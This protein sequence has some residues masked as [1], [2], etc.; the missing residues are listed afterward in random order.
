MDNTVQYKAMLETATTRLSEQLAAVAETKKLINTVCGWL[1]Q[2]PLYPDVEQDAVVSVSGT[3]R[4]DQF[5]GQPLSTVVRQILE[6]RKSA[7][8]GPASVPEIY[9]QMI[10]GAYKFETENEDN[11]KR[12][13]R[14]SLNKNT[15]I[16]HKLPTGEYGL[17][18]WYPN[19]KEPKAK[20]AT[21]NDESIAD[22]NG[23][24]TAKLNISGDEFDFEK[25]E[26]AREAMAPKE[27]A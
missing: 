7:N 24:A 3:F 27:S 26:N 9:D 18:L 14:Q 12:T 21:H 22:V 16:F 15:A 11:A 13:L 8:L 17:R 25:K 19:L 2:A 4:K 6:A 23:D 5:Y 20:A 10:K 1:K